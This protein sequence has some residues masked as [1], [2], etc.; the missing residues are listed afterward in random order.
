MAHCNSAGFFGIVSEISLRVKV[1]VIA[2]DFYS[3]FIRADSAVRAETPEFA[4]GRAFGRQ[5]NVVMSSDE[6]FI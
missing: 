4:S 5:V 6:R 1:G 2:D 3:G